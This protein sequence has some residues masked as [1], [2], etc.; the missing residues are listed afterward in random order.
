[1]DELKR[2]LVWSLQFTFSP[3]EYRY[4]TI[5]SLKILAKKCKMNEEDQALFMAVY[6][7]MTL[8]DPA[9]LNE[10]IHELIAQAREEDP[11]EPTEALK[12]AIMEACKDAVAEMEKPRMKAYKAFVRSFL[13]EESACGCNSS[14]SLEKKKGCGKH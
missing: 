14:P 2:A 6:D 8:K 11:L 7:G 4:A 3:E 13:E 10:P 5:L 12:P 1:M 9:V